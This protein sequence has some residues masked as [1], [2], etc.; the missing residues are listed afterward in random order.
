MNFIDEALEDSTKLNLFD[1]FWIMRLKVSSLLNIVEHHKK[2]KG[3]EVKILEIKSNIVEKY[4]EIF[5]RDYLNFKKEI[6]NAFYEVNFVG[7]VVIKEDSNPES[8]R[9]NA[10]KHFQ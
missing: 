6:V 10:R 5:E 3:T 7:E 8:E 4:S 2:N 9:K 1:C